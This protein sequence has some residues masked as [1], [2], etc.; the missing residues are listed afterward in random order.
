MKEGDWDWHPR[1]ARVGQAH[2]TGLSLYWPPHRIDGNCAR[3]TCL[4]TMQPGHPPI[5][6]SHW[7][8]W[9]AM[10]LWNKW[11]C[12]Y[13]LYLFIYL[14]SW[15]IHENHALLNLQVQFRIY[16]LINLL[17][18][19]PAV[20]VGVCGGTESVIPRQ[21]LSSLVLINQNEDLLFPLPFCC[22]RE[23]REGEEAGT[24]SKAPFP[25]FPLIKTHTHPPLVVMMATSILE[26]EELKLTHTH[27]HLLFANHFSYSLGSSSQGRACPTHSPA[28]ISVAFLCD[29]SLTT[30]FP[31][32]LCL[33]R[34]I[35]LLIHVVLLS[36]ILSDSCPHT[37]LFHLHRNCKAL[38][39]IYLFAN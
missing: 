2:G 24:L 39:F 25:P 6:H 5:G 31:L 17:I 36:I 28:W 29:L 18:Y 27:T 16:L 34:F 4:C 35:Y 15:E 32:F 14:L 20:W 12:L 30:Y 13:F 1:R 21:P 38:V 8:Q 22:E 26:S 3:A 33:Y 23:A 10:L 19:F 37:S 9:V 11:A 7:H